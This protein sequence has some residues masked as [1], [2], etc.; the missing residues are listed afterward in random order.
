MRKQI[1]VVVRL[2]FFIVAATL[3]VAVGGGVFAQNSDVVDGPQEGLITPTPTIDMAQ[4]ESDNSKPL[5]TGGVPSEPPP[6]IA[7]SLPVR[8]GESIDF[9]S[10]PDAPMITI[11]YG[12]TQRAGAK[13]DPQK[14]VNVVGTV[15]PKPS[16]LTYSLNNGP[17]MTLRTGPDP[18]RLAQ[19]G[20]FNIE[21]DYTELQP[22]ANQVLIIAKN[23]QGQETQATV[24]VNY[25]RIGQVWAKPGK[26][27]NYN[28]A[29]I[30]RIDD[31]AQVVD[32]Q[33]ALDNVNSVVRP[34]VLAYDRL[35]G[36]GDLSWKDYTVTV[37]I[38]FI[39]I[40]ENGYEFPSNGAAVGVILRWQGHIPSGNI[41]AP[42][43]GWKRLG[44][45]AFYNWL[46]TGKDTYT[47]SLGMYRFGG[48]PSQVVT[49]DRKLEMNTVYN[50]KVSVQST[51]VANPPTNYR[52]KV[53]DASLPEPEAWDIETTGF[54][55][56]PASGGLMLVA[57][58]VDAEFGNVTVKLDSILPPPTLTV[59]KSGP[60]SGSVALSPS[61]Q[62]NTYRFGEDV[63]LTATPD[64]GSN[65]A[66]WQGG[67]SGNANPGWVELFTNQTVTAVFTKISVGEP[68]SD[69]FSSCVLDPHWEFVDPRGH[70]TL[71][72]TGTKAQISVPAGTTHDMYVGER[73]A[74][75]IMQYISNEDFE[76]DVKFDSPMTSKYQ[77]Q[78]VLVEGDAK[79]FLRYNFQH[80]GSTYEIAAYTVLNNVTTERVSQAISIGT[81]MYL[82][83]KRTGNEW[84]LSYSSNGQ[85]WTQAAQFT[86]GLQA[87]MAGVF[88]GN[89]VQNPEMVSQIDYFFN[90][91]SPIVPQDNARKISVST[92]G[93]GTGTVTRTPQ[94]ENYAC[95]EP[96]TFEAVP[97]AGSLFTGWGGDLS[98]TANPIT[99]NVTDDMAISA[100]FDLDIVYY[101]LDVST[102]GQGTVA[103]TPNGSQFPEGTQVSLLATPSEGY[104]FVG[105][106][107]DISGDTNPAVLIMDGDKSV[108]AVFAEIKYSLNITTKG[109]GTVTTTPT[110]S[111][112]LPGTAVSLFASPAGGYKFIRWEGDISGNSN[113]SIVYMSGDKSVQAVFAPLQ[114]QIFFP[115][116]LAAD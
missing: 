81:P 106:K 69:D 104:R 89:A 111:Q 65:F 78:G 77:L 7:P 50:F 56:E 105:W 61:N 68:V 70:S 58:H 16:R 55:G 24:T 101:F 41:T 102:E 100:N 72:M 85:N 19:S 9:Q 92:T 37:P 14:W 6:F 75:R 1:T 39:G 84:T 67:L 31:M 21:L 23:S 107:G 46:R 28:W 49:K 17:T 112:F 27:Y 15:T 103:V 13:G 30:S 42:L 90:T 63:Q 8:G 82:R 108:E 29:D 73:N 116:V 35:I 3:L 86:F 20:D 25:Q 18:R 115:V 60:G 52:F 114:T 10:S 26:T 44:T 76:F 33:W 12:P 34:T 36:I 88:A 64:S 38:K 95:N 53:W 91:D 54:P 4:G 66:G 113:P 87:T 80:N 99:V 5:L 45:F 97:A 110:G 83:T 47:E 48:K 98:G 11:W 62:T 22:G 74:P 93:S 59:N 109:Q 2:L 71:T 79:N 40:N 57:H 96:V 43:D 94:K 51:G 32:G